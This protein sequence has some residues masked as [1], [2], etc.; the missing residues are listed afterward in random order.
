MEDMKIMK[1]GRKARISCVPLHVLHALHGKNRF[2]MEDMKIMKEA[3]KLE[4][5][6]FPSMFFMRFM[7]KRV[8]G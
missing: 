7:V 1:E 6:V 4:S 3:G 2:T 8:L 5:V